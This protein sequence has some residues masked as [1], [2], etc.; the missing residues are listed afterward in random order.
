ML[1]LVGLAPVRATAFTAVELNHAGVVVRDADGELT[2]AFV[3][4][5]EEE[6]SGVE[7]L[8]RT[9]LPLVTVGF[10]G[11][12]EG[13]CS[14]GGDGCGLAECRRN[15]C[16]GGPNAPYWRY[17]RQVSPG[18]WEPLPLGASNAR[19]RDGQIDGWSWT[20]AEAGLPPLTLSEVARRAGVAETG[21]TPAAAAVPTAAV[22]GPGIE[23]ATPGAE[24]PVA[25]VAAAAILV[26]IGGGALVLGRR[27]RGGPEAAS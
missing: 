12:G 13:V 9:G 15:V 3:A 7:L 24:A 19:V 11:L 6:I 25:Y 10:G 4:F 21:A 18:T 22:R 14:V 8:R 1:V 20:S 23:A 26:A 27:G 5:P 2:Y 17:F 16:Q